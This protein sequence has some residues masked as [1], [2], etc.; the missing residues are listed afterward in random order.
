MKI[1]II[2]PILTEVFNEEVIKEANLFKSG[3]TQIS[4]VN[5]ERGTASIESSYDEIIAGPDIVNKAVQAE[6]D[7]F[8][9]IFIDCFGDPA[10]D[11]AREMVN[12]PVVGG[13]Q[14]AV[15]TATIL[16]KKWS[17]VT[18]LKSVVPLI[19][20]LCKKS[21]VES[22]VASMRTIDTPV[23]ELHNKNEMKNK[24]LNQ[25]DFAIREDGAEGIVLGCTGML[26]MAQS[27]HDEMIKKGVNIPVI[28]P[29]ASAIGFL[30]QLY[31]S[32]VSHSKI[33]YPF[34]VEK[35]RIF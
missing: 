35:E 33:S 16:C 5:L 2:I 20:D 32:K 23:L 30:E 12:I 29:T 17:V 9:G 1:M 6:K 7:G 18:V 27:L 10:V 11:A 26:G 4:V 21:G 28:D 24:L 34:P 3:D 31:R 8:D 15:L 14:P 13:F 25:I 22:N 19:R